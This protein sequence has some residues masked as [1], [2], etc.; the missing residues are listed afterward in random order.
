MGIVATT[1]PNTGD[2]LCLLVS[3]FFTQAKAQALYE[4]AGGPAQDPHKLDRDR[5][6]IA[7]EDLP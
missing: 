1:R 3:I 7:C 4:A 2:T 5:N 6:G